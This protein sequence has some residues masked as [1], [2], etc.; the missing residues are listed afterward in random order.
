[1]S[2]SSSAIV[3]RPSIW[4]AVTSRP[5]TRRQPRSL[6]SHT[7][8]KCHPRLGTLTKPTQR[9]SATSEPA[10][11]VWHASA[12]IGLVTR[13]RGGFDHR[14]LTPPRTPRTTTAEQQGH[15]D[16]VGFRETRNHQGTQ[17]TP[18]A[19]RSACRILPSPSP[20]RSGGNASTTAN[21]WAELLLAAAGRQ[22][23]KVADRASEC[24]DARRI[25]TRRQ[26]GEPR[27]TR[28]SRRPVDDVAQH[29]I[30]LLTIPNPWPSTTQPALRRDPAA[31]G[32]SSDEAG[33][34]V[35]EDVAHSVWRSAR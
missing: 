19:A 29:T 27:C 11:R 4:A 2:A 25:C 7:S 10:V 21:H 13:R 17:P 30:D 14:P 23:P 26:R 32:C 28:S 34:A 9:G 24:T 1:M 8:V 6:I 18:T 22:A 3:H 31:F 12:C 16:G 33:L 20:R 5:P 15:R 35:D